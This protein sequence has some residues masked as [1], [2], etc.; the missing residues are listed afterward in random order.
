MKIL[1]LPKSVLASLI[2]CSC[3]LTASADYQ[4]KFLTGNATLSNPVFDVGGSVGNSATYLSGSSFLG[5]LYVGADAGSLAAIGTAQSFLTGDGAG[6][7][8]QPGNLSITHA[9][10]NPGS[11]GFYQLRVWDAASGSSYEIASATIG[12]KIGSSAVTGITLGGTIPGVGGNP[13]T[14]ISAQA[15]LHSAFGLTTVAVP[16]PTTIALG[17]FGAAGLFIRRRK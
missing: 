13:D 14:V 5:Q 4:I 12:A 11:S 3:A 1:S 15:N 2:V 9:S 6:F 8:N 10:L 16:E 7:I 17:L